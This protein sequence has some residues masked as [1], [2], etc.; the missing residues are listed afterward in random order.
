MIIQ[1]DTIHNEFYY[2]IVKYISIHNIMNILASP[3]I[4]PNIQL[5]NKPDSGKNITNED[6]GTINAD[7]THDRINNK[8]RYTSTHDDNIVRYT[9]K[10]SGDNQIITMSTYFTPSDNIKENYGWFPELG[11]NN[12]FVVDV[13]PRGVWLKGLNQFVDSAPVSKTSEYIDLYKDEIFPGSNYIDITKISKTAQEKLYM[14]K[15]YDSGFNVTIASGVTISKKVFD[16]TA[17]TNFDILFFYNTL[18]KLSANKVKDLDNLNIFLKKVDS[19]QNQNEIIQCNKFKIINAIGLNYLWQNLMNYCQSLLISGNSN[20]TVDAIILLREILFTTFVFEGNIKFAKYTLGYDMTTNAAAN[21]AIIAAITQVKTNSDWL[22]TLNLKNDDDVETYIK[23]V[24]CVIYEKNTL[25]VGSKLPLPHNDTEYIFFTSQ[26]MCARIIKDLIPIPA[27]KLNIETRNE[28]SDNTSETSMLNGLK[29][30]IKKYNLIA[31][32]TLNDTGKIF[33]YRILKFQGDSSHLVFSKILEEAKKQ[34]IIYNATTDSYETSAANIE[35]PILILTGEVPLFIRAIQEDI[36]IKSKKFKI[37]DEIITTDKSL[38]MYDTN[39]CISLKTLARNITNAITTDITIDVS[40]I[41]TVFGC[42]DKLIEFNITPI[43]EIL[44]VPALFIDFNQ[45]IDKSKSIYENIVKYYLEQHQQ[46]AFD[47]YK[48]Y[49][50]Q[51]NPIFSND[52]AVC[53]SNINALNGTEYDTPPNSKKYT[54]LLNQYSQCKS[55]IDFLKNVNSNLLNMNIIKISNTATYF[56]KSQLYSNLVNFAKSF[57]DL[58]SIFDSNGDLLND[59]IK[60]YNSGIINTECKE[61]FKIYKSYLDEIRKN[62]NIYYKYSYVFAFNNFI[63]IEYTRK[64][65]FDKCSVSSYNNRSIH[66]HVRLDDCIDTFEENMASF[67]PNNLVDYFMNDDE[68]SRNHHIKKDIINTAHT[69]HSIITKMFQIY[70]SDYLP[71][72]APLTIDR[73]IDP[74]TST[75]DYAAYSKI[76]DTANYEKVKNIINKNLK[77]FH[78]IQEITDIINYFNKDNLPEIYTIGKKNGNAK[79]GAPAIPGVDVINLKPLLKFIENIKNIYSKIKNCVELEDPTDSVYIQ[80]VVDY[81]N[82]YVD[83][84]HQSS[85]TELF[86]INKQNTSTSEFIDTVYANAPDIPEPTSTAAK[87]YYN[88]HD[89]IDINIKCNNNSGTD[90][91]FNISNIVKNKIILCKILY[92]LKTLITVQLHKHLFANENI[93]KISPHITSST[94]DTSISIIDALETQVISVAKAQNKKSPTIQFKDYAGGAPKNLTDTDRNIIKNI[95]NLKLWDANRKILSLAPKPGIVDMIITVLNES[96]YY[97]VN[98][99][100]IIEVSKG[101]KTHSNEKIKGLKRQIKGGANT[102][103]L[104]LVIGGYNGGS[105]IA[106]MGNSFTFTDLGEI[107][108]RSIQEIAP[109][110]F[111]DVAGNIANIIKIFDNAVDEVFK[112][113]IPIMYKYVNQSNIVNTDLEQLVYKR[114]DTTHQEYYSEI[115]GADKYNY[116]TYAY[117]DPIKIKCW[118]AQIFEA[119]INGSFTP[120]AQMDIITNGTP[121]IYQI[122]K[123]TITDITTQDVSYR[124]DALLNF[125]VAF[126]PI[127]QKDIHKYFKSHTLKIFGFKKIDFMLH[128]IRNI[129]DGQIDEVVNYFCNKFDPNNATNKRSLKD[130]FENFLDAE[131]INTFLQTINFINIFHQDINI[132]GEGQANLIIQIIK[133]VVLKDI[134]NINIVDYYNLTNEE[135]NKFKHKF[136]DVY[137]DK[138][139]LNQTQKIISNNFKKSINL[140]YS[141]F[142]ICHIF[143]IQSELTKYSSNILRFVFGADYIL[144]DMYDLTVYEFY[145]NII[146]KYE[147][148]TLLCESIDISQKILNITKTNINLPTINFSTTPIQIM[149]LYICSVYE[150]IYKLEEEVFESWKNI[151][152]SDISLTS[153]IGDFL[154]PNKEKKYLDRL[155]HNLLA[156]DASDFFNLFNEIFVGNKNSKNLK[157]YTTV[158]FILEMFN[159]LNLVIPGMSEYEIYKTTNNSS[160][161]ELY[162]LYNILLENPVFY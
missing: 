67:L 124:R 46:K 102:E 43:P 52:K 109:D 86:D 150:D 89:N 18:T 85:L 94:I 137:C 40:K 26:P 33:L 162:Y 138:L 56:S 16:Y 27:E 61:I 126:N 95:L 75:T 132:E 12:C 72:I 81:I 129:T 63:R 41:T 157:T 45:C 119:I 130:A 74:S 35:F 112:P 2:K 103:N 127:I 7:N 113:R 71:Y 44:S 38:I 131:Q 91:V 57:N 141:D 159:K 19:N 152:L 32:H 55:I 148:V 9:S 151:V 142:E 4:N 24:A 101:G 99:Y 135:I 76:K 88:G 49:F 8:L 154:I 146:A 156:P 15:F 114:L 68:Q 51:T 65:T 90:E 111:T 10:T 79:T 42:G 140:L 110:Y 11:V 29:E 64:N 106:S 14:F 53:M 128:L 125:I 23:A 105:D 116:R 96:D 153:K 98:L 92:K 147:Y 83:K 50:D 121:N 123:I 115:N 149:Y 97:F 78:T 118:M 3:P 1:I 100:N 161:K 160:L 66:K 69:F 155:D 36:S 145:K 54:V 80:P 108:V 37:Y 58:F 48:N 13:A 77:N 70:C 21:A 6:I 104:K 158:D 120:F 59:E 134:Y 28:D 62:M 87:P 17:Y 22:K 107:I 139:T 60:T 143:N 25:A 84:I 20:H 34:K 117:T 93:T 136:V 122:N 39:V 73:L 133:R 47:A 30:L 144:Q 82:H 31:S 5:N